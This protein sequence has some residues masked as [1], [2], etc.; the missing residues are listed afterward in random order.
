AGIEG[1]WRFVQRLWRLTGGSAA[2]EGEDKDLDRKLHRAVAGV[3][4]DVEALS[5]N[6]A[7]AKLYDLAN[8]IEK[9]RPS[10]SRDA[11]VRTI[12]RLV[13]PM[14]P[15]FAEEAWAKLGESGLVADA[16]WP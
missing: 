16:A 7:V 4:E 3:A 1:A 11:A 14:V 10:A 9:A 5:F 12:V 13:A 8:A 6:K 2:A 15:H